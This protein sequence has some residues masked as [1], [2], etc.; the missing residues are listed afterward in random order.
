MSDFVSELCIMPDG[1]HDDQ[2]DAFDFSIAVSESAGGA[3]RRGKLPGSSKYTGD[4]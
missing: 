2:F 4:E 1:A 3:F